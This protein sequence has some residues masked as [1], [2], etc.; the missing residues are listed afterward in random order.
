MGTPKGFEAVVPAVPDAEAA[1]AR[2]EFARVRCGPP[3]RFRCD[4][5][6]RDRREALIAKASI[7]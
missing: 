3:L 6:Q 7:P 4:S 2:E 5:A 1:Q